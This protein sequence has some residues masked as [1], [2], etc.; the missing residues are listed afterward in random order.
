MQLREM[1]SHD[2]DAFAGESEGVG[3]PALIDA[4][5]VVGGR[6]AVCIV[7]V[8]GIAIF[9]L[10]NE[11]GDMIC[12]DKSLPYEHAKA[13]A[14]VLPHEMYSVALIACGFRKYDPSISA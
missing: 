7:D 11:E 10:A 9:V 3:R 5:V 14:Q 8:R 2:W 4:T 1:K 6:A 12:F 13:V